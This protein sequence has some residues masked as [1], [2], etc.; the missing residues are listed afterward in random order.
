MVNKY[1]QQAPPGQQM[2]TELFTILEVHDAEAGYRAS[3]SG[4]YGDFTCENARFIP[5][6]RIIRKSHFG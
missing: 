4:L 3:L 6:A 1:G 2:I 5:M